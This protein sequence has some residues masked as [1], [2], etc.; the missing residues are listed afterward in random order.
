M[1]IQVSTLRLASRKLCQRMV[2][3]TGVEPKFLHGWR[4][5]ASS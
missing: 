3:A 5:L 2:E 4:G 1:L